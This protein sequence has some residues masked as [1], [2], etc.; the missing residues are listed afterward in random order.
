MKSIYNILEIA[1]TH[2]GSVAYVLSLL[3]EFK[4]FNKKDGFGIKFQPFKYDQISTEQFAWYEVYKEL[5]INECDWLKIFEKANKT[6]DIW[7]DIFD[8]YGVMILKNNLSN[9]FGIKL[10]TSILD[11]QEVFNA[12]KKIDSSRLKLIINIAGRSKLDIEDLV[13]KYES[14]NFQELLLETGFQAYPTDLADSGLS[15]IK[16]LKDNF[17]YKVVFADHIDGKLKEA[18]T[19]L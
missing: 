13:K 16:Y 15:K 5:F 2:G 18:I 10:Q 7:L 11:N 3:D 8:L 17:K 9:I 1:N 14:L 6:K 4:E 19:Y 12:L